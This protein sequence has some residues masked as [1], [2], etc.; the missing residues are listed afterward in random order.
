M[1]TDTGY[2]LGNWISDQRENKELNAERR[3]EAGCAGDGLGEA[4]R[5]GEKIRTCEGVF[6]AE[7]EPERAG[8][9]YRAGR[10]AE[11]VGERAEADLFGKPEGQGID[12][13]ADRASGIGRHAVEMR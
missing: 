9:L 8:E 6:P 1:W 11:Q 5:M 4:G 7:R 10:V 12:E 13:R 3:C 2:K